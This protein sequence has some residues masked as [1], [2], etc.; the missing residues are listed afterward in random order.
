VQEVLTLMIRHVM[1]D[2]VAVCRA[3]VETQF[4]FVAVIKCLFRAMFDLSEILE[5]INFL[6]FIR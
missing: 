1:C 5:K 6:S 3:V 4:H 2:S